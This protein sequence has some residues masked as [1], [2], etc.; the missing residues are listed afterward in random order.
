[1]LSVVKYLWNENQCT[2]VSKE[3]LDRT[4]Y[5]FI[6]CRW[7]CQFQP[8]FDHFCSGLGVPYFVHW[9]YI[10]GNEMKVVVK[11]FSGKIVV[12]NNVD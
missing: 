4:L 10:P 7:Y 12:L 2:L 8:L 9:S 5:P 6:M 3:N 11:P 1:M